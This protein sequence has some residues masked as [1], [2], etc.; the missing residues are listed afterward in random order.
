[1]AATRGRIH[2]EVTM[3][4]PSAELSRTSVVLFVRGGL[5]I[6]LAAV[7]VRWPEE[8]LLL[9]MVAAGAVAGTLGLIEVAGAS[10]SK[11]L[12]SSRIFYLGHG[13]IFV[14]FGVLTATVSV[15]TVPAATW[16]IV[17]WLLLHVTYAFLLAARLSYLP[18]VRNGLSLWGTI[19]L[20]CALAVSYLPAPPTILAL[21]LWG[22]LYVVALGIVEVVAGAW[23]NKHIF[24]P[25][26]RAPVTARA[27]VSPATEGHKLI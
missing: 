1:M 13:L 23:I 8:T 12:L 7:A 16:L 18:R 25:T 14:G 9:A 4:Q 17:A 11:T 20:G 22:A 3:S 5:L 27:G 21:Y 6:A 15:A 19:N 26:R 2:E 24:S 10:V